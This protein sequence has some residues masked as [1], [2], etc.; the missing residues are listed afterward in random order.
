M[1]STRL[2]PVEAREII[3]ELLETADP[4]AGTDELASPRR[5][6]EWLTERGLLE[7]DLELTPTDVQ[8]AIKLREA[9]RDLLAAGDK[10]SRE[11]LATLD[12]VASK[13]LLRVRFGRRG[14]VWMEPA[15]GGF[16][17][18][19]ARLLVIYQTSQAK[20]ASVRKRKPSVDDRWLTR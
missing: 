13:A 2:A 3:R 18:A 20:G 8:L 10:P 12:W 14:G 5:L 16:D 15:V 11:T 1:R 19:V 6:Y 9:L 17:G 7:D 4:E